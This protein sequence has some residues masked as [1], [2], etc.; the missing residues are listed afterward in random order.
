MRV[1]TACASGKGLRRGALRP[2]VRRPAAL[3]L[4]PLSVLRLTPLSVLRLTPLP[5]LGPEAGTGNGFESFDESGMA[6]FYSPRV[7]LSYYGWSGPTDPVAS[8]VG[9]LRARRRTIRN[10]APADVVHIGWL[11]SPYL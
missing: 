8:A 2:A 9:G 4:A 5:C 7:T 6:E 10:A 1:R 3:G 11:R